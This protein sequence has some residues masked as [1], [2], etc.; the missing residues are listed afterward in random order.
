MHSLAIKGSGIILILMVM[1]AGI[2]AALAYA[3]F[4]QQTLVR[5][6]PSVSIDTIDFGTVFPGM[7][8][9]DSFTV[10]FTSPLPYSPLNYTLTMEAPAEGINITE[11]LLLH[12]DDSELE[13]EPDPEANGQAGDT[14]AIGTVSEPGDLQ[15]KWLV[16]FTVPD[17]ITTGDYG[18]SI[19]I[20]YP[21]LD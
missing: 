11:Y 2:T 19:K 21:E 15:D 17:V 3:S 7:T 6:E 5:A 18:C 13:T 4:N 1:V 12:K 10:S 16:T 9:G 8:V 20:S 14:E